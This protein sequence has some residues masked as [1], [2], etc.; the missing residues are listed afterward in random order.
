MVRIAE[1]SGE[2][3][4]SVTRPVPGFGRVLM[5]LLVGAGLSLGLGLSSVKAAGPAVPLDT[6][7]TQ[8]L[9]DRAALQNGAKLYMNYCLGC[10]GISQVRYSRLADLGL[11]QDQ[12]KSSLILTES[13]LGDLIKTTMPL[14]ESA[15]WFGKAPPDL[16]LTARSRSSGAGS[17]AD[18]IYTYM[19]GYYLDPSRPTGW[20]NTVYP[21]VGMP[22]VL[23]DLQGE[24]TTEFK[25]VISNGE[26]TLVF[27][28][29]VQTS[30]GKMSPSEYDNAVADLTAFLSWAAEPAAQTRK[31][32]GVWVLLFLGIFFVFAWRLNAAYWRDIR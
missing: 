18:W 10:H 8:K 19:R 12:I 28:R 5:A 13:K 23:W 6:F 27:D 11:S 24:R 30:P 20:N 7:P 22:H 17:G 3:G 1:L 21:A 15:N 16:S 9:T 2:V 32:I 4:S 31:Q 29:F 25:K 26:E 14:K